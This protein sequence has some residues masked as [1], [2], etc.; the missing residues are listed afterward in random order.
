MI[1]TIIAE[2]EPAF[3]EWLSRKIG[4][5]PRINLLASTDNSEDL[6]AL[7]LQ[8][9]PDLAILDI[10]LAG[11]DALSVLQRLQ[12]NNVQIPYIVLVTGFLEYSGEAI[13]HFNEYLL[14]YIYKPIG[15]TADFLL[16]IENVLDKV[17]IRQQAKIEKT[18]DLPF[19]SE[20]NRIYIRQGAFIRTIEIANIV[21]IKAE[22]GTIEIYL[23]NEKKPLHL[24]TTLQ[25]LLD[26]M[27]ENQL[28]RIERH[29][30][31]NLIYFSQIN[32]LKRVLTLQKDGEMIHLDIGESYYGK[33]RERL[34]EIIG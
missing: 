30:A 33:L 2:D 11:G 31:I 3:N 15:K 9:K 20:N 16:Q 5:I 19:S 24:A 25:S 4:N 22:K 10:K 29:Y 13:R 18:N 32:I 17:I 6:F 28:I 26:K 7:L 8:H 23:A 12:K 14:D 1:N 21:W 34:G 27:P